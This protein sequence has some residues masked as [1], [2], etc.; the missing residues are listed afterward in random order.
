MI[1]VYG[2]SFRTII[3]EFSSFS[4]MHGLFQAGVTG[5]EWET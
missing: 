4:L 2:R 5:V 3:F 1:S